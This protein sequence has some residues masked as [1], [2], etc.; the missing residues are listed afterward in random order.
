MGRLRAQDGHRVPRPDRHL[1]HLERAG[2]PAGRPE[3]Q[4]FNWAG[5]ERDYARLLAV[6]SQAAKQGNPRARIVF[7]ATTYWGDQNAG[8]PLF[9]ER[10]LSILAAG[11]RPRRSGLYFDAVALNLYSS[12]DDLRRVA[13]IYRDVLDR[14]G[15]AAPSGSP[16]PTPRRMTTRCG[17][18]PG[19]RTDSG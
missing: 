6:A 14:Y 3:R 15:V 10:T 19:T 17:D 12:P 5:D 8:R 16:R 7:A 2:H 4:Y 9:L 13:G 18:W 11:P 1:G